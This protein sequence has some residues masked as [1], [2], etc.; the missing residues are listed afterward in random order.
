[1]SLAY[2][3]ACGGRLRRNS[4]TPADTANS[5]APYGPATQTGQGE[6]RGPPVPLTRAQTTTLTDTAVSQMVHR[7]LSTVGR[8]ARWPTWENTVGGAAAPAA[9]CGP[10]IPGGDAG[11]SAHSGI[12]SP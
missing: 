1:M 3:R 5:T 7:I 2:V 12:R 8:P 6:A 11:R 10:P 4:T 9:A